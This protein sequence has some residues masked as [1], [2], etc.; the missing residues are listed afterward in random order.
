MDVSN[1]SSTSSLVSR[2]DTGNAAAL[3]VL[4]KANEM[5]GQSA[6]TLIQAL[7]QPAAN[8]PP[9]LGNRVNTLV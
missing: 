8:N 9:N 6:L 3:A 4:K 5:E 2:A 7:P 1:V